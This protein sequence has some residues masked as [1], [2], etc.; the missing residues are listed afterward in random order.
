[1]SRRGAAVIDANVV[2]YL[3]ADEPEGTDPSTVLQRERQEN[4]RLSLE[5]SARDHDIIVPA[6]VFSELAYASHSSDAILAAFMAGCG[7]SVTLEAFD[8]EAARVAGEILRQMHPKRKPGDPKHAM[9]FDVMVAAVAHAIGAKY[10]L[11]GDVRRNRF[12][13]YLEIVDSG[14]EL[15]IAPEL[16]P[17]YQKSLG[18]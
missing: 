12:R 10:L 6:P 15:I 11:T 14:T 8:Y 16:P 13:Q 4:T 1:M 5:W 7:A 2:I 3:L 9:K 18:L 17:G